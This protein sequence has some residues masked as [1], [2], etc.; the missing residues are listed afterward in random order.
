MNI[1]VPEKLI[2]YICTIKEGE[3]VTDKANMFMILGLYASKII[4]LEKA[5]ELAGRSVWDFVEVLKTYHIPWG[6]YT[7][8]EMQMDHATIERL[9]ENN[10]TL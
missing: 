1:K 2:P 4:T 6:E 5:S 7:G 10:Y 9:T 8:E 3:T